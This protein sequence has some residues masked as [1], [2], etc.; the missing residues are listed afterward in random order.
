LG[1]SFDPGGNGKTKIYASAARYFE[2]VPADLAARQFSQSTGLQEMRFSDPYLTTRAPGPIYA[3]GL[4]QSYVMDGT[5]LPYMDEAT[6]GWQQLLRPDLSLE[7][8]GIYRTQGR[9]LEDVNYTPAE[10]VLNFYYWIDWDGDEVPD[11]NMTELPFPGYAP[12]PFGPYALGNLGGSA[13]AEF[14]Q[15]KRD[16]EALEILLNK[17]LSNNW[18]LTANYRYARLRGNY[19]GLYR[20]DN[21]QAD[22]NITSLFDFPDTPLVHGQ[23]QVGALNTDRPRV[24]N[25]FGSWFFNHGLELAGAFQWASGVPRTPLLAHPVYGNDG[26]LPGTDPR[27]LFYDFE[28]GLYRL[29][30]PGEPG[31][32]LGDYDAVTRGE[33]GRTPDLIT[34][35]LHAGWTIPV[36]DTR[37]KLAVDVANVTNRQSADRYSDTLEKI[38]CIGNPNYGQALSYQ[39]PRTTTLWVEWAW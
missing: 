29:A 17:R 30:G 27:Y 34:L 15:P 36:R 26:E 14:G 13:A 23:Y 16:F 28:A 35:D 39:Q 10:S 24:L 19:E 25:I 32:V 37:L 4:N 18:Q 2:R 5:R 1:V 7:V 33:L 12:R 22:P 38:T 8:R 20:N 31:S 11:D 3:G 9:V 21:G 6:L